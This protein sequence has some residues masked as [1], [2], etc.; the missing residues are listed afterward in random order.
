MLEEDDVLRQRLARTQSD[1]G[2]RDRTRG[3]E[4]PAPETTVLLVGEQ[5]LVA[6]EMVLDLLDLGAGETGAAVP[7]VLTVEIVGDVSDVAVI[8]SEMLV[9]RLGPLHVLGWIAGADRAA[10]LHEFT[11]RVLRGR[12]GMVGELVRPGA[13]WKSVSFGCVRRRGYRA[14]WRRGGV[15]WRRSRDIGCGVRPRW[16]VGSAGIGPVCGV[17]TPVV[18]AVARVGTCWSRDGFG[19]GVNRSAGGGSI[20]CRGVDRCAGSLAYLG[21]V[22]VVRGRARHGGRAHGGRCGG[23]G[24]IGG[25]G[26]LR[27]SGR[28]RVD[29]VGGRWGSGRRV[30]CVGFGSARFVRVGSGVVGGRGGVA[31]V[32]DGRRG[33][34]GIGC[35][36]GAFLGKWS[37]WVRVAAVVGGGRGVAR[38]GRAR[39]GGSRV[40]RARRLCGSAGVGGGGGAG[41]VRARVLGV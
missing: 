6:H 21:V 13:V 1:P 10:R 39:V 22:G 20:C 9:R 26:C 8:G 30:R 34:V 32:L 27:L 12:V 7:P 2:L 14:R 40:V 25:R 29:R 36:R 31:R 5:M 37:G 28:G 3:G 4:L 24:Q 35:A 16:R 18:G 19:A 41:I 11:V 33:V 23:G 15:G 17:G 38:V